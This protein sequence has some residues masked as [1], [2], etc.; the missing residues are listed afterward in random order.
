VNRNDFKIAKM[1]TTLKPKLT[2]KVVEMVIKETKTVQFRVAIRRV[3]PDSTVS[4]LEFGVVQFA[5]LRLWF[6]AFCISESLEKWSG[7]SRKWCEINTLE[8]P[9]TTGTTRAW[10]YLKNGMA[11]PVAASVAEKRKN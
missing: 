6:P 3:E 9:K 5:T 2:C 8:Y 7:F 11:K 1:K 4:F 10:N